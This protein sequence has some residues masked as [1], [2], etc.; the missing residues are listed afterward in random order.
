MWGVKLLREAHRRRRY[1]AGEVQRIVAEYR[2]GMRTQREIA[3]QY[4]VCVGTLR[5]W[6]SRT[7]SAPPARTDP[8]WIEVVA[9]APSLGTTYRIELPGGRAL[10]LGSGWRTDAV[11]ELVGLLCTP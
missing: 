6:L 5:N 9:E 7:S 3:D 1:S 11:R 8:G 10:V 2:E 4:G